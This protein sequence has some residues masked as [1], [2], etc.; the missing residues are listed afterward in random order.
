MFH[1][2]DKRKYR[3]NPFLPQNMY[4]N[5]S[6]NYY[7]CPMGQHLEPIGDYKTVSDLGYES[8]SSKYISQDCSGCPLRGRCYKGKSDR[9]TIEVNHRSNAFRKEVKSLL[10][11]ERGLMHRSNRPIEP[12]AVFGDIKFNHGFKRFRLKSNAKVKVEFGL[13]AVAH[14]LRKYIARSSKSSE[15]AL[16]ACL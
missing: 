14:N 8:V 9:R 13:V 2:E 11:S 5:E 4:Y 7:V 6:E 12:E 3:N 15:L 16:A 1:A 10:T